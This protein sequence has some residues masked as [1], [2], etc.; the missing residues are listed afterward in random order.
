MSE[1][2]NPL[3]GLKINQDL[4][5]FAVANLAHMDTR[6]YWDTI[7]KRLLREKISTG[8]VEVILSR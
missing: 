1:T 6:I 8:C 3:S 2:T 4:V 5:S 7:H